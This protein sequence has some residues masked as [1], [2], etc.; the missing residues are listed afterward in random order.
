MNGPVSPAYPAFQL[1]IAGRK[2]FVERVPRD[3]SILWKNMLHEDRRAPD[4]HGRRVSEYLVVPERSHGGIGDEVQIPHA[5]AA[6]IEREM[7]ALFA[8]L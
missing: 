7:E 4:P 2:R 5:D 3:V 8:F 6:S 1:E